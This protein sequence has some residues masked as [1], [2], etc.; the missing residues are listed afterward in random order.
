MD[1]RLHRKYK[2]KQKALA[3]FCDNNSFQS[4][5]KFDVSKYKKSDTLFILGSGASITSIT[6]EQWKEISK[7]DSLGFNNWSVHPFIPTYYFFEPT[8]RKNKFQ[9]KMNEVI[10]GNL[11][12]RLED[13]KQVPIIMHYLARYYFPEDVMEPLRETGNLYFQA[14]VNVPGDSLEELTFSYDR[15]FEKGYFKDINKAVYRRGSV[16]KLVHFGIAAGYKNVV[17]MGVD[18]NTSPYFFDVEGFNTVPCSNEIW[19]TKEKPDEQVHDTVNVEFHPITMLD[20]LMQLND[21]MNA[22]GCKLFNGSKASELTNSSID[23]YW[24]D[25]K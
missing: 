21:Q 7:S 2:I 9:I 15:A 11:K 8:S 18:L 17:L 6:D 10:Y 3:A 5:S 22:N 1:Y 23:F 13:Y 20:V 24:K 16:A 19:Y 25:L 12:N 4:T 14:P